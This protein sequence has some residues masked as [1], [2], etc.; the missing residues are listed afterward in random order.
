LQQQEI[1]SPS[2]DD[3]YEANC[4]FSGQFM[5]ELV[6]GFNYVELVGNFR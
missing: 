3:K 2:G 6:S 1:V 4:T 5:G